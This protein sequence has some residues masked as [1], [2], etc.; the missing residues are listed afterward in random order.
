MVLA[1]SGVAGLGV[2]GCEVMVARQPQ[3]VYV[4][5]QPPAY[6]IVAEAP[7]A[8]QIV[9]RR[10]APPAAEYVWVDG[11][12]S[13]SGRAY[14]WE[15]GRWAVPPHA[16]AVWVGPRYER[17]QRGNRYTAGHWQSHD[18]DAGHEKQPE[19]R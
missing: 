9:E 1:S 11:Y 4:A 19:R 13:W 6:V 3:A 7:P 12:Y 10:P 14:V 2:L 5:A 15:T 16:H 17:D 8:P 18:Q